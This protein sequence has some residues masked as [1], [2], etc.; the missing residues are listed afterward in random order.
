MTRYTLNSVFAF[1][2][3]RCYFYNCKFYGNYTKK[4]IVIDL[5]I[6]NILSAKKDPY[7]GSFLISSLRAPAPL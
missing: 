6:K 5:N 4:H 3:L 1:V 2:Y 7:K